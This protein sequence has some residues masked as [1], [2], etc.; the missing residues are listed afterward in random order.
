MAKRFFAP[1]AVVAQPEINNGEANIKKGGI[2]ALNDTAETLKGE[3]LV[4]YWS[5]DGKIVSS[6]KSAVTLSPDSSTL[7]GS[8]AQ[9][10]DF[11]EPVFLHLTLTTSKGVSRNDWHFGFYKDMPLADAKVSVK[12]DGNKLTLSSDK[13]AFFVWANVYG[14]G[15]E[16]NDNSF[17]LLPGRPRTL[18]WK[19]SWKNEKNVRMPAKAL[20][21]S[22][23][24]TCSRK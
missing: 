2:Y 10:V 22:H 19:S 17:T 12:L 15:G 23:L 9:P 16:F 1:V 14:C 11:N 21:V 6:E 13:P 5:Y 20:T 18:E 24:K 7:V 3:L 4:E 8:F